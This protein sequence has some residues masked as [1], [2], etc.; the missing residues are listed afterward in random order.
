LPGPRK[1]EIL[2]SEL[3]DGRPCV[4]NAVSYRDL[5]VLVAGLMASEAQG[6]RY[7]YRTASSFVRVR[8][9]LDPAPL[10]TAGDFCSPEGTGGLVIAGSFVQRTTAQIEAA[11][12]VAGVVPLE[13]SVPAL[14]GAGAHAEVA[15][16]RDEATAAMLDGRDAPGV[17]Q[18]RAGRARGTAA[19]ALSVGQ[20]ISAGLVELVRAIE[21]RPAW[22]IAKGGIT[23]SDIATEALGVRRAWVRG[24]AIPGVPVWRTGAESRWPGMDYVVFPGNV[25]GPGALAEMIALLHGTQS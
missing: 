20:R 14:L 2:L 3:A 25:G 8:G 17:H 24:Q 22:I 16:V 11:G 15:R 18:P 13:M 5:E 4:V 7:L 10:L 23:S 19:D 1:V 9:G 12:Q 21:H 6:R